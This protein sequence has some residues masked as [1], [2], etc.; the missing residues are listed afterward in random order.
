MTTRTTLKSLPYAKKLAH[1]KKLVATFEFG[2]KGANVETR[3]ISLSITLITS[4]GPHRNL[5]AK[6]PVVELT[7][8]I[9]VVKSTSATLTPGD[10]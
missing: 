7:E 2:P 9:T 4:D 3:V 10:N 5:P 8:G 6:A 1:V